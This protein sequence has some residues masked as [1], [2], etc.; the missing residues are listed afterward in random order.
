MIL[1]CER[2]GDSGRGFE[3]RD[4]KF[5]FPVFRLKEELRNTIA[6][7]MAQVRRVPKK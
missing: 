4:L 7:N 5:A 3:E 1:K 6:E 2:D